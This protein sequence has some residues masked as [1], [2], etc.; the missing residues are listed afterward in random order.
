MKANSPAKKPEIAPE[1]KGARR[2]M[3]LDDHPVM[4]EGLAQ[5]INHEADLQVCGQFEDAAPAFE[6]VPQLNPDVVIIDL[7]LKG[8]SGLELVKNIKANYPKIP[9]LVLSMHDESLYAERALRAGA[10]GYI[11]KA[12]ATEAVLGAIRHVL[13]GGIHL[14]QKMSSKLMHQLASGRPGATGSLMERL[15]DRELEVFSL[16]GQGRGT[17]QIAEQLHLSVKTIE[18]HRAHIKEKLNLKNATE[19]VH[20]AIQ[21]REDT[22]ASS[23]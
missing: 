20:R 4:R 6:A 21:M 19:L 10:S 16:I 9:L 3:L 1:K 12:E 23:P 13:E 7:S 17:R 2:V 18:S 15:S 8:S 11:M 14:S 22:P 5:L